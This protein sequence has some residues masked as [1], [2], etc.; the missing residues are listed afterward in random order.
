MFGKIM[1]Y[2]FGGFLI[3]FIGILMI[4]LIAL[5]VWLIIDFIRNGA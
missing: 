1:E 5:I 2:M 3:V 4:A